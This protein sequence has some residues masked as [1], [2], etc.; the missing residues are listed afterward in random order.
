MGGSTAKPL[1]ATVIACL[2]SL[3]VA[4]MPWLRTGQARR[5][6]FAL[7]RSADALGFVDSP[8]R[9]ALVVSWYLLPLLT[10]AAWTAGALGRPGL[11]AVLGGLVGS[12]SAAAGSIVMA[13]ARPE[14][15]PIAA[16]ATGGTAIASAVWL[17]RTPS[18]RVRDPSNEGESA[19]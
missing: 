4:F 17:G 15:G 11:V 5:T 2:A 16:I 19:T 12:M 1:I 9:R 10:A 18:V 3:G 8:L 7:A 6:A 13:W 14:S